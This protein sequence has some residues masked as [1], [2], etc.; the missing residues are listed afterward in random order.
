MIRPTKLMLLAALGCWYSQAHAALTPQE[1]FERASPS[2][3]VVTATNEKGQAVAYGSGVVLETRLVA[4]NCHVLKGSNRANVQWRG[5]VYEGAFAAGESRQDTCLLYVGELEAPA[6]KT[7]DTNGVRIGERIYAIGN[8]QGL[9]LTLTEGLVSSVRGS[10][11]A[12]LIQISAAISPGSSGGGVFD[13]NA[14]LVGLSTFNLRDGQNLNFAVPINW[15]LEIRQTL[16]DKAS[17][18][19]ILAPL[20]TRIPP[21]PR[22]KSAIKKA[23]WLSAMS[24]RLPRNH[25]PDY[26]SRMEF[27]K[28]VHFEA[29]RAGLDPQLV[30]AIIDVLSGFKKYAISPAGARGYMQVAPFW[31]QAIGDGD[32]KKLFDMRA[33]LRYGCV[34]LRHYLDMESGDMYM[35]LGRY[36]GKRGDPKFINLVNDRWKRK[37]DWKN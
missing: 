3:V 33:N 7:R 22:F 4:T 8:P 24:D 6:V 34:I 32:A 26:Q 19:D 2:I 11:S 29:T 20:S 21:E 13:E 31:V 14:M 25:Q 16:K 17:F 12:P 35:A 28:T 5:K 1:I 15:A 30:L 9:E 18:T 37:W 36:V 27:L 10:G 23:E